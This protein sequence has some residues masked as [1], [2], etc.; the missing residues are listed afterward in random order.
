[1][2]SSVSFGRIAPSSQGP[3]AA[4]PLCLM[5]DL[6][7]RVCV[8]YC[9][10]QRARR[11]GKK[12]PASSNTQEQE[13]ADPAGMSPSHPTPPHAHAH[14][15]PSFNK[16]KPTHPHT[17]TPTAAPTPESQTQAE[18]QGPPAAAPPHEG[19]PI[20]DPNINPWPAGVYSPYAYT[21]AWLLPGG[22]PAYGPLSPRAVCVGV[23]VHVCRRGS[24]EDQ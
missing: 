10:P 15:G 11:A 8:C 21:L 20:V 9:R 4:L 5:R 18:A 24:H 1:M 7:T 22:W 23:S 17:H 12:G 13:P 16:P 6:M 14:L 3:R 2:A 19:P